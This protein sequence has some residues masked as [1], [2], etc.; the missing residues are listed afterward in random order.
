M[1]NRPPAQE[2]RGGEAD[3]EFVAARNLADVAG[4]LVHGFKNH[5]L[6]ISTHLQ[7]ALDA[8]DGGA[9]PGREGLEAALRSARASRDLSQQLLDLGRLDEGDQGVDPAAAVA[10][11]GALA[12]G[13]AGPRV[14]VEVERPDHGVDLDVGPAALERALLDLVLNARDALDAAD[15]P[16]TLTIGYRRADGWAFLWV[17]DNGPG[18]SLSVANRAT[19][20]YFTTK[21]RGAGSGLGLAVARSF[22]HEAGGSLA[23]ETSPEAG[24]TVT[25][26]LPEAPGA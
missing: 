5:L 16:G 1:T 26:K 8:L 9:V 25:L 18:M 22:A 12:S 23:I 11:I 24:T 17:A 6:V 14:S 20:P 3:A 4:A 19:D 2:G 15:R 13:L 10:R 21:P 7:L